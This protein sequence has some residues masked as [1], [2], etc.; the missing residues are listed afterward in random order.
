M[1][2]VIMQPTYL[3][4]M[5]YFDLIDQADTF[6]FL[7]H[8]QIVKRSWGVRNRIKNQDKELML[9]APVVSIGSTREISYSTAQLSQH[10]N[11]RKKHLDSIRHAYG[12]AKF[13]A[14]VYS[15]LESLISR[16]YDSL[17]KLNSSIII[18]IANKMGITKS[19]CYSSGMKDVEG[20]KDIML[21]S[22]CKK[23]QADTYLS[24]IGSADYIEKESSGGAFVPAGIEL[25]Y[26]NFKF[27]T[28]A[29]LGNNF[30]SHL[31]VIDLL[32]NCGYE[33]ALEI[34]RSGRRD[35][36]SFKDISKFLTV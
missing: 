36:I 12:R 3:P 18:F 27:P 14:E 32:M 2:C 30:L 22:I 28:Y 19:I 15:D 5:G 26:Q 13:F 21:V 16:E 1:I 6:V 20:I 33:A 10:E 11:W 25:Y 9:T 23:M 35:N 4:W 34:I 31:S 7:D 8:V 24:P 29:Q 17:G